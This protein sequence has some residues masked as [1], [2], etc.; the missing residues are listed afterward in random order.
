MRKT[1]KVRFFIFSLL[2]IFIFSLRTE[3]RAYSLFDELSLQCVN[4]GDCSVCDFLSI[5]SSAARLILYFMSGAALVLLIW[6]GIG[7]VMNWGNK[8]SIAANKKLIFNTLLA[9]CLVMV[10]WSLISII[11]NMLTLNKGLVVSRGWWQVP[12]CETIEIVRPTEEDIVSGNCASIATAT[13]IKTSQ[14]G[15]VSPS[16]YKLLNCINTKKN[17]YTR[18]SS[19]TLVITSVSDNAGLA[20]CRD[21]WSDAVCAH[22]YGSCHYGGPFKKL[23]GSYAVDFRSRGFDNGDQIAMKDLVMNI[24]GGNFRYEEYKAKDNDG[25]Y[26]TVGHFH[27]SAKECGGI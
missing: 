6:G 1:I 23:D 20:T 26:Y 27:V 19:K 25:N 24:C 8:E 21:N 22:S 11:I 2:L 5:F 10:L 14:C 9:V 4:N 15:D 7:L 13:S 16:L 17:N 12:K 18:L 3:V